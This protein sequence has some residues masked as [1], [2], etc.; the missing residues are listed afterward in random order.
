MSVDRVTLQRLCVDEGLPV[1]AVA[2]R[3]G[4][5]ARTVY[6][7]LDRLGLA[8]PSG[9]TP[10]APPMFEIPDDLPDEQQRVVRYVNAEVERVGRGDRTEPVDLLTA[11]ARE[12]L[13]VHARKR[14]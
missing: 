11:R 13:A 1:E 9:R 10:A 6:R 3:L 8:R 12:I 4:V 2:D 14:R 7:A 5:S